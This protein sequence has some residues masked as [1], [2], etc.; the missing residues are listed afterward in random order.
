MLN[1]LPLLAILLL[2]FFSCE[3]KKEVNT[4][5]KPKYAPAFVPEFNADSAYKLVEQQVAFG[6]RVPETEAH[7]NCGEF[8]IA[9]LTRYGAE[10]QEQPIT[11][12]GWNGQQ[13]SGR[14]I[15]GS[16][17]P[18]QKKR[19]LLAAHW[20]TR[21]Y[22]D[23]DTVRKNEPIPGANDGASGVAVALE[24]IRAIAASPEKPRIGIDV[25]LF[26]L[27]DGG[28]PT[29]ADPSEVRKSGYCLGSEAWAA[30]PHQPNYKAY[31]GILFDMVGGEGAMFTK[32]GHSMQYAPSVVRKVWEQAEQLG[33]GQYFSEQLTEPIMDDHVPVNVTRRIPMIDIIQYNPDNDDPFY[34]HW[35]RHSD[36]LP[37][38]SRESLKAVGQTVL[39][40]LY[41]E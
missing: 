22:A 7:Y 31:Y 33:Y 36:D 1:K 37:P 34:T 39:R 24:L 10:V 6:Y 20:D 29:F 18:E 19:V 26:D 5:P 14:N 21:P 3:Q 12:T 9:K 8:L 25:I 32:E 30:N 13:V 28:A 40:T 16:L 15:I 11:V 2:L 27:E 38:I 23:Q 35:H 17:F 41:H 4:P